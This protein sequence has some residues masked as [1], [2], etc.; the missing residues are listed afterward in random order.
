M[1][2]HALDS[3]VQYQRGSLHNHNT[4]IT[5][6]LLAKQLPQLGHYH[7]ITSSALY[8][9]AHRQQHCILFSVR[10]QSTSAALMQS[11]LF[12]IM[13]VNVIGVGTD[14]QICDTYYCHV[15]RCRQLEKIAQISAEGAHE[16]EA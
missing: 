4:V 3:L 5:G 15:F 6:L 9:S 11:N 2:Q 10:T 13:S 14:K 7:F 16:E 8:V 1:N 12:I